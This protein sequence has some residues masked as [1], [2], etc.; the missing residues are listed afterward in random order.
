MDPRIQIRTKISWIRNTGK[1]PKNMRTCRSGR[2]D[3]YKGRVAVRLGQAAVEPLLGGGVAPEVDGARGRH[4][5]QV[6][7]QAA[8]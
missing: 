2:D 5:H 8:E 7:S 1:N 3:V 6:G 4:P